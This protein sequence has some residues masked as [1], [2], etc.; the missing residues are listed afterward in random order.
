[1]PRLVLPCL[2]AGALAPAAANASLYNVQI[3][4]ID[5]SMAT[6]QVCNVPGVHTYPA[7]P[8]SHVGEVWTVDVDMSTEPWTVNPIYRAVGCAGLTPAPGGGGGV[9][10]GLTPGKTPG[11]TGGG[12]G[13]GAGS[14][15]NDGDPADLAGLLPKTAFNKVF[16]FRCDDDGFDDGVVSVTITS[17][18]GLGKSLKDDFN[19]AVD[20]QDGFVLVGKSV[21][22]F[23]KKGKKVKQSALDDATEI[24]VKGKLLKPSQWRKDDDGN[25]IPTI[26]AKQID[27][28]D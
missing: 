20:D 2:L 19:E 24:A 11:R 22:V 21:R 15:L 26:R 25:R 6:Y 10:P 5:G 7:I 3:L 1:M 27:I 14:I 18:K 9:A 4:T 12:S 28:R 16:T 13:G 17:I 8:G 23:N